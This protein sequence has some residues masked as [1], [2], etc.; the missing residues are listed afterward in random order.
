MRKLVL[1]SLIGLLGI[2]VGSCSDDGSSDANTQTQVTAN[3]APVEATS[4]KQIKPAAPAPDEKAIARESDQSTNTMTKVDGDV[5]K[6][7]FGMLKVVPPNNSDDTSTPDTLLLSG[8]KVFR[9]E[10]AF[11]H[12]KYLFSIGQ[13]DV[14]L[15]SSVSGGLD[16]IQN[17]RFLLLS[18]DQEPKIVPDQKPIGG[19]TAGFKSSLSGDVVLLDLGFEQGKQK[20]VELRGDTVTVRLLD[21]APQPLAD[22]DCKKLFNEGLE[23]C[24]EASKQIANCKNP[25]RTFPGYLWRNVIYFSNFPVFN[26]KAFDRICVAPCNG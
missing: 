26:L 5:V 1:V 13:R 7:R 14:V 23:A 16:G 17:L 4:K 12:I 18:S 22:D 19:S 21:A 20:L 11:L 3:P 6:T 10:D 15:F 8:K 2:V 25:R 9:E 24:A